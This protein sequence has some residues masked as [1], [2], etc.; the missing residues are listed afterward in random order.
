MEFFE[1]LQRSDIG[2]W[3]YEVL[4]ADL[5]SYASKVG[6]IPGEGTQIFSRWEHEEYFRSV[7][8]LI[9]AGVN[10]MIVARD[11]AR[12]SG[13]EF[14]V[15]IRPAAWGASIPWE[16]TFNSKFYHAHPEWHCVD[17]DGR[18][19]MFMSYAVPQVR[20]QVLDILK[21][22]VEMSAPDGVGFVFNR[23]MPLMLWEKPFADQFRAEYG[24][25][26]MS[27]E[28]EDPRIHRLRGK[29]MTGFLR[30]LRAMLDGMG[31]T[32]SGKRYAISVATLAEKRFNERFGLDVETWV[33]EGLIDQVGPILAHH[34]RGKE[35][36]FTPHD[37]AYY[38]RAVA[39]SNVRVLPFLLSWNT[40]Q[41][42]GSND[43]KD[44]CKLVLKWHKDGADGFGLWDPVGDHGYGRGSY[45][46]QPFDVLGRLEHRELI[47]HWAEHGVPLPNH[48]LLQ[49]LGD[50]EYS[51]WF[52]NTGY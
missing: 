6:T 10:P 46:G 42:T 22:A 7:T 18:Q 9:K 11:A 27:V 17:R 1:G 47:A 35:E 14:H 2:Q 3:W 19:A 48:F 31:K 38:R 34:T 28:A 51:A 40:M 39:G 25:D 30:D 23:G 33:K 12:A 5:V 44:L 29:I 50:N 41:W 21:E 49:K 36:T 13:R 52:P 8:A 26:V 32:R 45:Q 16:E 4:G 43:P 37:V 15:M 20:R 24:V